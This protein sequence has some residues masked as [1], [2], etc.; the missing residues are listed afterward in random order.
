MVKFWVSPKSGGKRAFLYLKF[1]SHW[2][3]PTT[4]NESSPSALINPS[5]PA[6]FKS[7]HA[8]EARSKLLETETIFS[9]ATVEVTQPT[10]TSISWFNPRKVSNAWFK[11][12][13][14]V[15]MLKGGIVYFYKLIKLKKPIIK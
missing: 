6:L 7:I 15:L 8:F 5:S 9:A 10:K 4:N 3:G 1:C 13:S 12:E 11:F 14:I 2:V